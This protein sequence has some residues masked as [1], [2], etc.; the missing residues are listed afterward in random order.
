MKIFTDAELLR[1]G[2]RTLLASWE[3]YAQGA[4]GAAVR[5]LPGVTAAVF[6]QR[7]ERAVYN[8]AL[9]DRDRPGAERDAAITAMEAAF[10]DA[11][12][13]EFA[14]WVHESDDATRRGLERRGYRLDSAT[15]AMGMSMD[16]LAGDAP[17]LDLMHVEWS[18]YVRLFNLPHGLLADADHAVFH[19]RCARYDSAPATTAMAFD[20]DGDCGIFNVMTLP[21]ARRRGL[22]TAITRLQLLDAA[23]RGCTTATLQSTPVAEG[24][25]T[26]IGFRDLGRYQEFVPRR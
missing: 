25:Y 24:V 6:P 21:R 2:E 20:H 26:A 9:L 15:R 12:V 3:A 4:T 13:V 16:A 8:N 17:A 5:H 22:G 14:A 19:L 18:E 11:G 10:G 1:R 7:P 23:A